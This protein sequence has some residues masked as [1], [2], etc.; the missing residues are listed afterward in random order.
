[1][2]GYVLNRIRI[3]EETDIEM[4][5]RFLLLGLLAALLFW[6]LDS[7]LHGFV[8]H[9]GTLLDQM[10]PP[11][12]HDFWK[13]ITIAA[14]FIAMGVC[15]EIMLQS[16]RKAEERERATH[17]ELNQ[18]FHIA[19]DGIRVI[20]L[21]FT[22][23][24]VNETFTKL[25]GW[26]PEEA[27]GR[28]CHEVFP[29][30]LCH[31][32]NCPLT[33]IMKGGERIECEVE[34]EPVDGHRASCI[35]TA[36]PYRGLHGE[37][38]GIVESFKDITERKRSEEALRESE[39]Q[40]RGLVESAPESIVMVDSEGRV[41]TCNM[42]TE[43]LTG[44]RKEELEGKHLHELITMNPED[45]PRVT[46]VFESLVNGREVETFELEIARK[47]GRRI[48]IREKMRIL[49][50]E[51]KITGIQVISTDITKRK[52]T[53]EELEKHREHL[54]ELVEE[55]TLALQRTNRQLQR[56]VVDRKEAETEIRLL[57]ER[58]EE[59][60]QE[61]TRELQ[62]AYE[63]LMELDKMKDS[64]LSSVSHEFRTPLTSIRSFAE[65]LLQYDNEAPETRKDFL[66]IIHRESERL[67]RLINDF[68]DLSK[69]EAGE[70]V[71]NEDLCFVEEI[72]HDVTESQNQILQE[73]DLR[74][75]T[76]IPQELPQVFVDRDRI[77]QV[78]TNLLSNAIK[79]SEKG[80]E[81]RIKAEPFVSR[82]SGDPLKWVRVSVSDQG[83]GIQEA[84]FENIF[85]KFRQVA[86]DTLKDKPKGTGLGLPIS[87]EIIGHYGGNVWVESRV[88]E[89]ST[90]T[91]ILPAS[92]DLSASSRGSIVE[93]LAGGG[94][95]DKTILIM[96][97]NP[98]VRRLL[99]S[100]LLRRGYRVLEASDVEGLL[101]QVQKTSVD[102]I[103]LDVIM[104][105]M[106]G[107]DT[108]GI[109]RDD[110]RTKNIPVLVVSMVQDKERGILLGANAFLKKPFKED[111]LMESVRALQEEGASVLVV[112]DEMGIREML[113]LQLE[114]EGY[115]V[116]IARDGQEALDCIKEQM[117][118]LVILDV[119]MPKKNGTEVLT[120]IRCHP[121]TQNLPVIILTAQKLSDEQTK[122]F[123]LGGRLQM[124]HTRDLSSLFEVI[125]STIE[126]PVGLS[127]ASSM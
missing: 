102:L 100:Q 84:E 62:R 113:R 107:H 52:R 89:G 101:G 31:T 96:D 26:K 39:K 108:L 54:E 48:W 64:F 15:V 34:K 73:K 32:E 10:F 6:V 4:K 3:K 106:D 40:Y 121:Q 30:H 116:D 91:F 43:E 23:R 120:W 18:I 66:D 94:Q 126:A 24:R 35:L 87:K 37:L 70:M 22:V 88:G 123:S 25:S 86:S 79:F 2:Y 44:Y 13:R 103:M 8:L 61:R 115:R 119:C 29:G 80:T 77:H 74:L 36:K 45:I 68:L 90:F 125:D 57:N 71:Y 55:R 17:A 21:D 109:I 16:R 46:E 14:F 118:D 85:D 33:R 28:K 7:A 114:E 124:D 95:M 58:L 27:E 56:E 75:K 51:D 82:R 69:I 81:I 59:R 83:L 72:I 1:M 19:S 93:T 65:I 12:S 67:T 76:D 105:L 104:P 38:L 41:R 11:A 42:A 47:D 98:K 117:P 112:D 9:E 97:E 60:V 50:A 110:P 111:E 122:L 20:D 53:D 127:R 63:E 49:Q 99:G 5:H 92:S 78:I